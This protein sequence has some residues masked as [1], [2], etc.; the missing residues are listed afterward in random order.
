MC[1]ILKLWDSSLPE[2]FL[3]SFLFRCHLTLL[4][5][6]VGLSRSVVD[7]CLVMS[8]RRHDFLATYRQVERLLYAKERQVLCRALDPDRL[9]SLLRLQKRRDFGGDTTPCLSI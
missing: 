1:A 6:L 3:S 4:L 2:I 8:R 9:P 5:M 7:R